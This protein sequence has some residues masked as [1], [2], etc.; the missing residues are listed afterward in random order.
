MTLQ[1]TKKRIEVCRC[2]GEREA[3]AQ[4]AVPSIAE[5]WARSPSELDGIADQPFFWPQKHKKPAGLCTQQPAGLMMAPVTQTRGAFA[6]AANMIRGSAAALTLRAE[7]ARLNLRFKPG[8]LT[9]FCPF[10]GLHPFTLCRLVELT[11]VRLG[12]VGDQSFTASRTRR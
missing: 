3:P 9:L 10:V 6:Q 2:L 8:I 7:G 1:L 12:E 11:E 4:L 5:H